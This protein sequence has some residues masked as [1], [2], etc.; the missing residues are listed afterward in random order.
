MSYQDRIHYLEQCLA[1]LTPEDVHRNRAHLDSAYLENLNIDIRC[2]R[3]NLAM[4]YLRD[5]LRKRSQRTWLVNQEH[6]GNVTGHVSF[7]DEKIYTGIDPDFDKYVHTD[8]RTKQQSIKKRRRRFLIVVNA[9]DEHTELE[10]LEESK[11]IPLH[12]K[13]CK[14][15]N[16]KE[17]LLAIP[18]ANKHSEAEWLRDAECEI[19]E[20]NYCEIEEVGQ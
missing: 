11:N 2:R 6:Y 16:I 8:I 5:A 19:N 3:D 7:S 18:K 12:V 17:R 4:G 9:V 1:S 13:V 10:L 15:I 20:K 14:D